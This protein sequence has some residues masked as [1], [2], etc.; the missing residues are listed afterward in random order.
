MCDFNSRRFSLHDNLD[1]N[2]FHSLQHETIKTAWKDN[3]SSSIEENGTVS[4]AIVCLCLPCC[5]VFIYIKKKFSILVTRWSFFQ[6]IWLENLE[7]AASLIR[8]ER[9]LG[10]CSGVK[11]WKTSFMIRCCRREN[12]YCKISTFF[13][14]WLSNEWMN[15]TWSA[16]RR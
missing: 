7:K 14:A 11:N 1:G 9:K 5:C 3:I 12:K 16:I 6:L 8:Q 2:F 4:S 13:S 10:S 15:E